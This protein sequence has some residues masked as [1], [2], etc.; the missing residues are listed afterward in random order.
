M[1]ACAWMFCKQDL[2]PREKG[3]LSREGGRLR[4]TDEP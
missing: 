2:G 4:G 3:R 1:G